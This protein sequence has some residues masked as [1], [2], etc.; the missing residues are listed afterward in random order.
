MHK[1]KRYIPNNSCEKLPDQISKI[2]H[3]LLG[4]NQSSTLNQ[5]SF[6]LESLVKPPHLL[7]THFKKWR[8]DVGQL[9]CVTTKK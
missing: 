9:T 7:L 6:L 5:S 2:F 3:D 1:K 8:A 4:Q